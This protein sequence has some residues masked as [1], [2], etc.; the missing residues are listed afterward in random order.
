MAEE[1]TNEFQKKIFEMK[2]LDSNLFLENT[3]V[4]TLNEYQ[5]QFLC[6]TELS[7][8]AVFLFL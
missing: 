2:C 5:K 3:S 4:I 1:M 6:L 8:S 7:M